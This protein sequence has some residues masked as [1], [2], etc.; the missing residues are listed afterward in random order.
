MRE[1]E[2]YA[3]VYGIIKNEQ[4]QILCMQRKNTWYMDWFYWLPAWHL[5]WEET[6][7]KWIAREL[8]EE[9]CI[10]VLENDLELVHTSH[11]VNPGE[12]V[13]FDFYFLLTS[14][15]WEVSNGEPEK[16]SDISFLDPDDPKIV[17]YLREVF[18]K[19]DS[20]ESF[21]EKNMNT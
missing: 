9:I 6:L 8:K 4:W 17:P 19:V 15:S 18:Q 5:E 13:Y 14:Y 2:Y 11:R 10:G 3:A 21:S 20:S 7:K 12:R 16:C 1:A